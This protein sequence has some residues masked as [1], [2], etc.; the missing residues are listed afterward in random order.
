M[1]ARSV[2]EGRRFEMLFKRS[3]RAGVGKGVRHSRHLATA[4]GRIKR[5]GERESFSSSNATPFIVTTYRPSLSQLGAAYP[6]LIVS[7]LA[8]YL[9]AHVWACNWARARATHT[10]L[11]TVTSMEPMRQFFALL[12]PPVQILL[13]LSINLTSVNDDLWNASFF[14][15]LSYDEISSI[16]GLITF[17]CRFK[18]KRNNW[19]TFYYI[20]LYI[21]I[22]VY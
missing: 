11:Y 9:C 3:R 6:V 13:L 22:H 4:N 20:W 10:P 14:T 5:T 8:A 1:V 18:K 17:I 12:Y 7:T 21:Y 15:I 2:W 19:I 16:V